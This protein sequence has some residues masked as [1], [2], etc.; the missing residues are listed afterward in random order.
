MEKQQNLVRFPLLLIRFH[1]K[2]TRQDRR[3]SATWF[4][5]DSTSEGHY[6]LKRDK[7]FQYILGADGEIRT[8]INDNAAYSEFTNISHAIWSGIYNGYTTYMKDTE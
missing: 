7:I 2:A 6:N 1:P 3:Y 8:F 4:K 5:I